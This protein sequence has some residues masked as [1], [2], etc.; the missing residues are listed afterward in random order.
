MAVPK[1]CILF[2]MLAILSCAF[3]CAAEEQQQPQSTVKSSTDT[4][5]ADQLDQETI[6][7][8]CN[9][10]FRTSMGNVTSHFVFRK[11]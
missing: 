6:M 2:V 9:E 8:L 7:M 10:T 1:Y 4:D 3:C 5:S 11:V